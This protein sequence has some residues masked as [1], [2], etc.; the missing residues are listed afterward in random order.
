MTHVFHTQST[1]TAGDPEGML[2]PELGGDGVPSTLPCHVVA[3]GPDGLMIRITGYGNHESSRAGVQEGRDPG[4][5]SSV[6]NWSRRQEREL[7]QR[8]RAIETSDP[9]PA[10][11]AMDLAIEKAQAFGIGAVGVRNSNHYGAAGVYAL[12]AAARGFIGLSGRM[13]LLTRCRQLNH[14]RG[15]FM[16]LPLLPRRK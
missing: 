5:V 2:P 1:P 6:R 3:E 4:Q 7:V 11:R 13:L 8:L 14:V 12:Q 16:G 10:V 15:I 9:S